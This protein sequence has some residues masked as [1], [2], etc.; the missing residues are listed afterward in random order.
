MAVNSDLIKLVETSPDTVITLI[1]GEKVV[2]CETTEE[3]ILRVV[4]FR[5]AILSSEPI[6][7]GIPHSALGSCSQRSELPR[8]S[9]DK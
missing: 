8:A 3:V 1:T 4:G 9:G 5:R 2:V 6:G 7:A